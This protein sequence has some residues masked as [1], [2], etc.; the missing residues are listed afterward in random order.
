LNS[1]APAWQRHVAATGSESPRWRETPA[2]CV[3]ESEAVEIDPPG[4]KV[5]IQDHGDVMTQ[6]YGKSPCSTATSVATALI[7][8]VV[9]AMAGSVLIDTI[10][11]ASSATTVARNLAGRAT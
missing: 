7:L 11:G 10:N 8:I 4:E 9:L 2:Q 6:P 1:L 5:R 3:L